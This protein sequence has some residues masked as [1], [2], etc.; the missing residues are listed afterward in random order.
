MEPMRTR[1]LSLL[2]PLLALPLAPG[3]GEE[4]DV[5]LYCAHDQVH[6]EPIVREFERRTGLKV[7][8]EYDIEA[9][10]TVGLVKRI[11]EEA[12]RRTRADVFWNNEIAHTV[13]LAEKGLLQPY[14]SPSAAGIPEEFRDQERRWTGFAARAR[15]Y[16]VNTDEADPAEIQGMWDLVDPR[17]EG[18]TAIA[19]PL[20]GTT[21]THVTAL[22]TALGEEETE[23][24]LE[25]IEERGVSLPGGNGPVARLVGE[26]ELVFGWTD[27]DDYN[28]RRLAG[29]PVDVVFPD[30]QGIGTLFIPNTVAMIADAPHPD[31]AQQLIDYLLSPEVERK[32]AESRSAQIPLHASL[33]GLEHQLPLDRMKPMKVDYQEVG[34]QID[35]RMQ[36]LK[37]RFLD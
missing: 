22:Y 33:A 9:H 11:E 17:W 36:E 28:V 10:K 14:D 20:T 1:G 26:G 32:L 8:A 13:N 12:K 2:V 15:C 35:Q 21:L 3:C 37:E 7:A 27:T 4:A 5:V 30:E 34:R 31:A 23:R 18:R 25:A 19:R 6:A 24:Y 16:I 29:D